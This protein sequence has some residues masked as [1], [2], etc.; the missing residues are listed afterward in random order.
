M[1]IMF[2]PE[3][4]ASPSKAP[5]TTGVPSPVSLYVYCNDVDALFARAT[6]AGAK[7]EQPPQ[8][9]FWGDRFC[10]LQDPDGHSWYFATHKEDPSPEEMSRRR[11]EFAKQQ[12]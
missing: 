5:A 12:K 6:A 1:V 11:E 9:M 8:D 2:G 10:R 7:A 4:S 3:C